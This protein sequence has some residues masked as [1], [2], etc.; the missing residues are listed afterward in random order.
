MPDIEST[1]RIKA[2]LSQLRSEFQ[3]ASR[4]IQ[5][6]NSEF[7]KAAA[8]LD[9]WAASAD[10]V[11]A[12][13]TQL[14]AT[15]EAQEKQQESLKKQLE[16][17]VK[18]YGENSAA[19]DRL[20][21][22]INNL[23]ASTEKNRK[24]LSDY[25][26][27]LEDI[28]KAEASAGDG[29]GKF[30]SASEKLAKTID[31]QESELQ[32]LKSR[33]KDVV[34]EQGKNSDSAKEL[35]K[36]MKDLSGDLR[37]NKK[38]MSDAEKAADDF[39][40]SLDDMKQAADQANDGFTTMKGVLAELVADGIKVALDG[41]KDLAKQ[42]FDVGAS[43]EHGMSE[44]EAIS[45]ATS[46]QME[47]ISD[48]AKEMGENTVFS[49]S[50]AADA[51]KY[52][53]MAGWSTEDMLGGIEGVMNLAAASGEDLGTTSDI[54]TDALTAMGYAAG[55]A[56][57]LADVMA[58][59][60]SN[61]NTNVSLMGST[62]QYAAPILGALGYNMED[63][64]V[65]IGLMANAG[66]KGQKAGT[67]LRSILTRL[68]APPKE[69]AEEMEKLGISIT[70]SE[71][72]MKSLDDIMGDMREAFGKLSETEKTAAAK[73]IAGAEAMSGLL[74]I[75]N[76]APAD[77]DKL[78][79]AVY[80]SAGAAKEMSETMND[81]VQGQITLLKS[82]VE[83]IMIKIF[84][85]AAPQ[86]KRAIGTIS[87]ALDD[88]NWNKVA[89]GVGTVAEKFADLFA[90]VVNHS[91]TV[92]GTLK[93]IAT[94]FVTYKAASLVMDFG[95]KIAGLFSLIQGGT[96]IVAAFGSAL[97]LNPAALGIAALAG[98]G[99]AIYEYQKAQ[100]AAIKEEWGMTEAQQEVI[101]KA[102]EVKRSYDDV[103]QSRS[104]ALGDVGAEFDY[105]RQLKDE[106]NKLIGKN[107]EVKQGYEDRANFILGELAKAMGIEVDDIQQVIDQN[108]RLGKSIDDVILKKQAEA[109]L[110]ADDAAYQDAIKNQGQ[111]LET[112]TE[113]VQVAKER[114]DKWIEA[115][116][117]KGRVMTEY[118][119]IMKDSVD[120]AQD[121]LDANEGVFKAEEETRKAM[122][123]S[124]AAAGDAGQALSEYNAIIE[125]HMNLGEAI[126]SGSAD[127]IKDALDRMHMNF[128]TA[129]D[130]TKEALEQQ[131]E[132]IDKHLELMKQAVETKA[133]GAS[134]SMVKALEG[135]KND[136]QHELDTFNKMA[137]KEA[138]KIPEKVATGI[139]NRA[140]TV[141]PAAR[142]L[143]K[144]AEGPL[145]QPSDVPSKAG[146][147]ISKS[148]ADGLG[149]HKSQ[150]GIKATGLK[151]TAVNSLAGGQ[152]QAATAGGNFGAGF[153]RGIAS[154]ARSVATAAAGIVGWAVSAVN[155][156]QDS[157]SPSR[158]TMKSGRWFTQGYIKGI[159]SET[160]PL[161]KAVETMV[162]GALVG[163]QASSK[164]DLNKTGLITD[165][166]QQISYMT[167]KAQY[168]NE[169]K[170]A[171]FDTDISNLQANQKRK[172]DKL[173]YAMEREVSMLEA[174]RDREIAKL[175]AI[176]KNDIKND[177]DVERMKTYWKNWAAKE[178]EQ[179]KTH[180]KIQQNIITRNYEAAIKKL[181]DSKAAYQTASQEMLSELSQAL[182]QYQSQAINLINSTMDGITQDY[183]QRY[184]ALI[185][186]QD[187]LIDKLKKAGDLF[188]ISD[189][190]VISVN[191]LEK[192]TE[193]IRT[194]TDKLRSVKEK[195][196]GELF[197]QIA[198]YDMTQGSAFMDRL[199][200]MS[201][202]DLEAYNRAYTAKLEAANEAGKMMYA[203]EFDAAADEYQ[204]S[205]DTAF[206]GLPGQLETLGEQTARGFLNGLTK[207]TDYMDKT[208]RTYIKSMIG[209][210]KD[211]LGIHSPS[212]VLFE[213]GAYTGEG[214]NN[215]LVSLMGDIRSTVR[216][217]TDSVKQ[218]ISG[219]FEDI[220]SVRAAA[221]PRGVY[222]GASQTVVNNT[223]NLV[224]NNNSPKSLSALDTYQARRQQISQL[225]A[226]ISPA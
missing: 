113:A 27:K 135:M 171:E 218:P 202:D 105:I 127:K 18:E 47:Q 64:A 109:E 216:D 141:L 94:V 145:A 220:P 119:K 28:Q 207:N 164:F 11:T 156:A 41:V 65:A 2:D 176:D 62:F 221:P 188:E 63:A 76:A 130:G 35:A 178:I 93:T 33:Y 198:S 205:L 183:D 77:F 73:H 146:I 43:F 208:V 26:A 197:E 32:D 44:V 100:E 179:T 175:D 34:L 59:A 116:K 139:Y 12:K 125:N 22:R 46:D 196:S 42:T 68:S 151:N 14:R 5:L 92:I 124:K 7:K 181:Q 203:D 217:I 184:D 66:I 134:E 23:E 101:D 39:D 57:K 153:A 123:E 107:G 9:D 129:K 83:G 148:Y 131:V 70:D 194:Y 210:F 54:V 25:E 167:A 98:L 180:T 36:E 108:G 61:A 144:K 149:L 30:E 15:I 91:D 48:K 212:R 45:G 1:A 143:V 138:A 225:K 122:L 69:C 75:V 17:T 88:I 82:K 97:A 226:A 126:Q 51:F 4:S 219:L 185:N 16:L 104:S 78:N 120:R 147:K 89:D 187:N 106:Y 8:G 191:D 49:A 136:A 168:N 199:L 21:I 96:G 58:A 177:T 140:D 166:E 90:Y 72:N 165:I 67:A 99:V 29:V 111:A 37:D 128:I 163:L 115:K 6:A 110:Q 71:G 38:Q 190:N 87:D 214:F 56:G 55:D 173:E 195:V 53:S 74:A 112:Y 158:V 200:A 182:N 52:M 222:A 172:I 142:D 85:R 213:I 79:K 186:K 117:E 189:A 204:K 24:S 60:S 80:N 201:S 169:K 162:S 161:R 40:R 84:E 121:Y 215:G 10:G 31:K 103:A 170:L 206:A 13:C 86:I 155:R 102:S 160:V 193:A 95:T 159:L 157:H 20:R 224:Q 209:T 19:A 223:Y 137:E 154:A 133:P 114:E 81:N 152:Q 192:Q 132:E 118:H 3:S 211:A 50:D 150:V 174:A